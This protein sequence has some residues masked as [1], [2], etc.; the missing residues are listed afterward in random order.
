MKKIMKI[1]GVL[2]LTFTLVTNLQYALINYGIGGNN[3]NSVLA[4]TGTGT[5]TEEPPKKYDWSWD[6]CQGTQMCN[7]KSV[8]YTGTIMTCITGYSY[9]ACTSGTQ[10]SAPPP[11][12]MG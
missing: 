6:N 1:T 8:S 9:S 2:V 10:C 3:L 12:P 4:E 5:G 11:C 7:G